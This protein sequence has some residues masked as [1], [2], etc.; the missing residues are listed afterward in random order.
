MA[1]TPSH[2]IV[3]LR[4]GRFGVS[5]CPAAGGSITR[6]WQDRPDGPIEWLRPAT[7][8]AI[9][10]RDPLGMASFPLVPFSS[11]IREGRFGFGGHAVSLPLNFP[12][13]RH[14]IHGHGWQA[15]WHIVDVEE[16]TATI[17]YTHAAD[18]WPWAYEAGQT[19]SLGETGLSL[20]MTLT[21]RGDGPMPAGLGPHPYFVRTPGARIA[22]TVDRLWGSDSEVMP[23]ALTAPPPGRDLNAG[24]APAETVMDN[25][26]T[27][28]DHRV[29]ISWPE[30]GARLV[31]EAPPP[32]DFLV[33]FTP[34]GEDYFCVEPVS[35][36]TDAFNLAAAGRRDTGMTV[37]EP[38]E[39]LT[40]IVRFRPDPI[41]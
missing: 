25:T 9:A 32:L 20:I 12:P 34:P 39:T 4:H 21:N 33:V 6:F 23:T 16:D 2:E 36:M 8:T 22:A 7:A 29:E 15:S 41:D 1:G 24:L 19:F 5:I 11:R 14:A 10:D 28:W 38:G 13:E 26:F 40:G 27:G 35:N 30:W 3:T 31:M 37:L 18:R 17:A